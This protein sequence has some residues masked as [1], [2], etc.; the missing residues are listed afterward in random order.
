MVILKMLAPLLLLSIAILKDHLSIKWKG[1][2]W[3][4]TLMLALLIA[5]AILNMAIM[6][7]DASHA[8][9]ALLES[10]NA[11]SSMDSMA[12]S[13]TEQ[14]A[15][16]RD[17]SLKLDPFVAAARF[18]YPQSSLD[19]GLVKLRS[20]IALQADRQLKQSVLPTWDAPNRII[21]PEFH[22]ERMDHI[23]DIPFVNNGS[24][25]AR[26]IQVFFR[27]NNGHLLHDSLGFGSPASDKVF[28]P[29]QTHRVVLLWDHDKPLDG[30]LSIVSETRLGLSTTDRFRLRTYLDS[31]NI[32]NGWSSLKHLY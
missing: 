29:G 32:H 1:T 10:K 6:A 28:S 17:V 12:V 18:K 9:D 24:G 3:V 23:L 11:R 27:P 21:S 19:D 15:L 4:P 20:E 2:K 30:V 7:I 26:N 25:P 13:L 5:S 14:K 8:S 16:V 31:L 22:H